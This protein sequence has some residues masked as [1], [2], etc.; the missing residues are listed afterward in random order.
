MV[1]YELPAPTPHARE[2]RERILWFRP[3][4]SATSP[5]MPA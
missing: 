2:L 5:N 1:V 4:L 3:A